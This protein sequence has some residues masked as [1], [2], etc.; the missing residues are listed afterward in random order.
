MEAKDKSFAF[1]F[2]GVYDEVIP[3]EL[4]K[5]HMEDGR[6][7]EVILIRLMRTLQK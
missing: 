1:D 2:E 7:V 4:I 3:H 5:Y 6:K